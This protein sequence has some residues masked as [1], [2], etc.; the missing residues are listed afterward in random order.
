[1]SLQLS[2]ISH[3]FGPQEVLNDIN[4][5]IKGNPKI[6][7]I[8]RNGSG[9]TTLFKIIIKELMAE[10]GDLTMPR[11]YKIA[12]LAQVTFEDENQTV[13]DMLEALFIPILDLEKA[14]E[15]ITQQL[16]HQVDDDLLDKYT[17]LQNQYELLGGYTYR[18]EMMNVFTRFGFSESDLSRTLSIFS[19]GQKTRLAFVRLLLSKPDLLLLDEPTNHL[20]MATIEWLE[21]YLN[22]YQKAILF[23]SHD[24]MFIDNVA[25]VIYELEYT[26][27]SYYP[28]NYSQYLVLKNQNQEKQ[29]SAYKR[30]QKDIQRLEELIEKFRYKRSKAK[31]AQSKIKYLDRMEKIEK[32]TADTKNFKAYFHS[33]VKG[34]KQV[35]KC[36][37]LMIGYD[38]LLATVDLTLMHGQRCAIIGPNGQGKTTFLK[39]IMGF[40]PSLQ[41][42]Y[43]MGHQIECGYFDQE[44]IEY[45]N[46]K[47]VLE[48]LWDGYPELTHTEVRTIL[49]QFLFT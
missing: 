33:R 12:S 36:D 40:I 19:S 17:S 11:D 6:A 15:K 22:H 18:Q 21:T 26:N 23:I 38:K 39:T 27:L 35:L 46:D 13:K 24:R 8:G 3:S 30:Q 4:L 34:G 37:H 41:G 42:E 48:E 44:L 45:K 9:K 5:E 10:K 7:L 14:I 43:L 16:K 32:P 47:T 25:D 20:D 29:L 28:G 1:M 31:F 2:H 49:G